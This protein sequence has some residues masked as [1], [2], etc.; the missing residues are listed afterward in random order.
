MLRY[1]DD[2]E[3]RQAIKKQFNKVEFANPSCVGLQSGIAR[4]H[5]G[6]KEGAG[7]RRILQRADQ[8]QHSSAETASIPPVGLGRLRTPGLGPVDN[9]V[10]ATTPATR[11][12]PAAKLAS[13]RVVPR[14]HRP[15]LLDFGEEILDLVP[16]PVHLPVMLPGFRPVPPRRD[17]RHR[18]A[19]LH[20]L[21]QPVRVERPVPDEGPEREILGQ[22]APAP[23]RGRGPGR[24]GSRSGPGIRARPRCRPPRSCCVRPPRERPIPWRQVPLLRPPP[25]GEPA[26]PCRR[27]T[28]MSNPPEPSLRQSGWSNTLGNARCL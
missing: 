13:V 2:L 1:A 18:A 21:E 24:E 11:W 26:R 10:A 5:A 19:S 28:P 17:H 15:E 27:R 9:H 23:P 3:L 22:A 25:S 12:I 16:P 14:R 7:V 4:T 6:R 8:E 20:I